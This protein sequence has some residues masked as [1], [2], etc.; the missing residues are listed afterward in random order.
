MSQPI[1]PSAE[2]LK[3]VKLLKPLTLQELTTLLSM[4]EKQTFEAHTNILIEGENSW[5]LYLV[6][7]GLV[8]IYKSNKLTGDFYDV[9]QL[10]PRTF[11]GEMSLV[12]DHP[13]SASVRA[14]METHVFY[15]SKENFNQFIAED[16]DRKI[17]FLDSCVQNLV[18]RL[19]ELDDN[20]VISQYQLWKTAMKKE[21][22]A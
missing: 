19:R 12:D 15:I 10:G 7:E 18:V 20:Y 16:G 5:G 14:L 3:E 9:G 2:I 22:A 13:R 21:A 11:F 4:G 1:E 8:G 17:R 6:L